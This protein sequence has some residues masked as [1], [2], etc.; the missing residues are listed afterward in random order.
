MGSARKERDPH[1][2]LVCA[3]AFQRVAERLIGRI[4]EL[5][6][7]TQ[8][9]CS[10]LGDVVACAVNL[11]FALELYLKTLLVQ[12]QLEVPQRHDLRNLYDALPQ[13]VKDNIE[14]AYDTA[15]RSQWYGKRAAITIAKGPRDEPTWT[16]YR[17]E[18]K[19]MG[20]LLERSND[21]FLAFR[22]IYEFTEPEDDAYQFHQFEYGLLLSACHSLRAAIIERLQE[23][24]IGS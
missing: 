21:V 11:A 24:P 20:A 23:P 5:K 12:L 10:G 13:E 14:K 6:E 2:G 19:D 4:G 9:P 16:D 17:N 18:A 7:G 15:W 3:E 22:Y 8:D 1:A